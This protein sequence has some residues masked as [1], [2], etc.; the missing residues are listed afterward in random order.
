[1]IAKLKQHL[2]YSVQ[3]IQHINGMKKNWK[4]DINS[5]GDS[6]VISIKL[7]LKKIQIT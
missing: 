2:T 4:K 3:K 5:N 6:F 1:M 7:D